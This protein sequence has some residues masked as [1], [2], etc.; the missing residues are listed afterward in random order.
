MKF[1]SFLNKNKYLFI[2]LTIGLAVFTFPMLA[3]GFDLMPGDRYNFLYYNY[4]LEHGFL[5]L[6]K[7]PLHG[8]FW[9]A[10]FPPFELSSAYD[11]T[12]MGLVPV[13]SFFRLFFRPFDS[14]QALFF[15]LCAIN[16]F[17]FYWFLKQFKFSDIASSFGAYIFAFNIFRFFKINQIEFF[18]QFLSVLSIIFLIKVIGKK[19]SIKNH[20]YFL[21]SA[22]FL[23]LQFYTSFTLGFFS[24]LTGSIFVLAALLPKKSRD[25]VL[26]FFKN[27]NKLFIFY[28]LVV[29]LL[30]L[31][32]AYYHS[33]TEQIIS[34]GDLSGTFCDR[35]CWVRNI[36]FL[37]TVFYKNLAYLQDAEIPYATCSLGVFAIIGGVFGLFKFKNKKGAFIITLVIVFLISSANS[38]VY[39]W[40]IAYILLL[41]TEG[42][43]KGINP[44]G[45]IAL[46]IIALGNTV[47]VDYLKNK[48]QAIILCFVILV[49]TVETIP[50]LND[51]NSSYSVYNFSKK[52]FQ[53]QL[54]EIKLDSNCDFVKIDYA[55][56]NREKFG[57]KDILNKEFLAQNKVDMLS[58]WV[59]VDKNI[60]SLNKYYKIEKEI[61]IP[62]GNVCKIIQKVDFESL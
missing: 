19:S 20:F 44:L 43:N 38:A 53:K 48:K 33:L 46:I 26:D 58:F 21:L 2:F 15:V 27:Y 16:Y 32:M 54:D 5:Y 28:L 8:V 59:S 11:E 12:L 14:Y 57:K 51:I 29:M 3:S 60:K 47:L 49:L 31:P 50:R 37:D 25:I 39:F 23:T 7:N 10:P 17:V 45:F 1:I 30:L 9:Q 6:S 35:L 13:Y 52:E 36:S 62:N 18:S 61:Q 55:P 41:G 42:L 56:L 34:F 4:I 40:K 22:V 24:V